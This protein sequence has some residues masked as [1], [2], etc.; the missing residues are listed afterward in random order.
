MKDDVERLTKMD[1]EGEFQSKL[2]SVGKHRY[3]V[4]VTNTVINQ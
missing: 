2:G 4:P 3:R 1:V